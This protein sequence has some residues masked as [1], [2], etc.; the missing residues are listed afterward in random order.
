M[1]VHDLA[2]LWPDLITR[3]VLT[4]G[5]QASAVTAVFVL[6]VVLISGAITGMWTN[7]GRRA[8]EPADAYEEAA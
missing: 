6:A 5:L 7:T 8:E 2:D 1:I 4:V 3:A